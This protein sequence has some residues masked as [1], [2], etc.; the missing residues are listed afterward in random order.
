MLAATGG[1]PPYL[2][3]PWE[4]PSSS[5]TLAELSTLKTPPKQKFT[6]KPTL[7]AIR[8]RDTSVLMLFENI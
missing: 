7:D 8:P 3:T 5:N 1:P 2:D 6:L 4:K